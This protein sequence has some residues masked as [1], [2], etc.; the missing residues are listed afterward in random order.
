MLTKSDLLPYFARKSS[1]WNMFPA[2]TWRGRGKARRHIYV[3][4]GAPILL[5]A[6]VDTVQ[7]PR[8]DSV[9]RGAGFDDRLGVYLGHRLVRERP[10]LYDLLL[11]DF[12]ESFASTGQYLAP[13]HD[14]NLVIELDRAGEDYVDYG[15]ASDAL[16]VALAD[17]GFRQGVGSFS[18][19]CLMSQLDCNKINLGLGT[20]DSHSRKSGFDMRAF[21]RQLAR[22]ETFVDRYGQTQWPAVTSG[23]WD[24]DLESEK[25]FFRASKNSLA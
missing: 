14:Y 7:E 1:V 16:H 15:L 21:Y 25:E 6:H 19:V 18:D 5:V 9:N 2:R 23:Y 17:A 4:N 12:E 3:D 22:L 11:T 13:S 10:D 20:F 24:F 8:L